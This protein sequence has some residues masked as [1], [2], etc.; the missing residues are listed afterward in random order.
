MSSLLSTSDVVD[1]ARRRLVG[2]SGILW[3]EQAHDAWPYKVSLGVPSGPNLPLSG[4]RL[5]TWATSIV[6]FCEAHGLGYERRGFR[7]GVRIDLPVSVT[8]PDE[9]TCAEVAGVTGELVRRDERLARLVSAGI[10]L[11]QAVGINRELRSRDDRS[12]ETLLS[13]G[14]WARNHETK[15]MTPRQLPIPGTQ[16][17]VLDKVSDQRVVCRI[18]GKDTLGLNRRPHL[19]SMKY[20]D[21]ASSLRFGQA[22]VGTGDPA[23]EGRPPYDVSWAVIVENRDTFVDFP[24]IERA[25]CI[26]GDGKAVIPVLEQLSWLRKVPRVFYW[27]DMDLDGL[28][29]LASLRERGSECESL[30][31]NLRSYQKFQS[32]GTDRDKRG[33]IIRVDRYPTVVSGLTSCER[34]LYEWIRTKK[35]GYPRIEQEKIPYDAALKELDRLLTAAPC[36]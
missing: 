26:L 28:M 13:I 19:L 16:G 27:G 22:L 35:L 31:M 6:K 2:S 32:V 21:P 10:D 7:G 36:S 30:L 4:E 14:L 33:E 8:F 1:R 20:L 17:K 3:R 24:K 18:A 25:V 29:I 23:D 9:L 12:F 34:S 5:L 11:E 15:G